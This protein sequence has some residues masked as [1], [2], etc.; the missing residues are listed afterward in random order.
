M[1]TKFFL[2]AGLLVNTVMFS[3][4]D[5]YSMFRDKQAA[6]L[7]DEN[8]TYFMESMTITTVNGE[9]DITFNN[10]VGIVKGDLTPIMP[11]INPNLRPIFKRD[12]K[13][14]SQD[15][16]I[17]NTHIVCVVPGNICI[18]LFPAD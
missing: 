16:G 6:Y 12:K 3:Q 18:I 15:D 13:R 2:F 1:K 14:K 5:K 11:Q 4:I 17:G 7:P 10:I 9:D 8:K